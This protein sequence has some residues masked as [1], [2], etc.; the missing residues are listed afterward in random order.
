MKA[1]TKALIVAIPTEID[2]SA[3]NPDVKMDHKRRH[4]NGNGRSS[5]QTRVLAS[6]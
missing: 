3:E 5:S 6:F 4:N 1:I 2:G